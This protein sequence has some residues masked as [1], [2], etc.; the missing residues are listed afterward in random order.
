MRGL[1][2]PDDTGAAPAARTASWRVLALLTAMTAIGPMSL[3]IL[4]PAV[5]GLAVTLRADP[6]TVQLTLSLYLLGLAASQLLLGPLAD[7]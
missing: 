5:P 3:N 4:V 7:R 2:L 6:A 1:P